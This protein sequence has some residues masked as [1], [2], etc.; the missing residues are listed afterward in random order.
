MPEP[1][2]AAIKAH[3]RETLKTYVKPLSGKL[4][5]LAQL[6]N[7]VLELREKGASAESIAGKLKEKNFTVSKDTILKFLRKK[8]RTKK[9]AS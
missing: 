2:I 5:V 6:K 7:E 4:R 1:D 9:N 3:L 8:K